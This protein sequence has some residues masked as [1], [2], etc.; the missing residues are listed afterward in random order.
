MKANHNFK[1]VNGL[2]KSDVCIKNVILFHRT[3]TFND[4]VVSVVQPKLI[5]RF[6]YRWNENA[7]KSK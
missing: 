1:W 7:I 3:D 6:H 5:S 4:I 2:S